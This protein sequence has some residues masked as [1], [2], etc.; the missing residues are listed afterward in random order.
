M[1]NGF[2]YVIIEERFYDEKFVRERCMG[3]DEFV[4]IVEKFIFGYVEK[5]IGVLVDLIV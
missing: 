3:F 5:I 4:K 1:I 2:I